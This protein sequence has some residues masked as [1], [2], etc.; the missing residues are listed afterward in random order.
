MLFRLVIEQGGSGLPQQSRT[1]CGVD[2][3]VPYVPRHV[4]QRVGG[5]AD[6]P[7]VQGGRSVRAADRGA[8]LNATEFRPSST[9]LLLGLCY[10]KLYSTKLN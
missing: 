4:R 10:I 7:G 3:G 9:C 2:S 1:M 8:G 5:R 6:L